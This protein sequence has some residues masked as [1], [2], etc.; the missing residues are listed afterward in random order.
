MNRQ[1]S[2][3]LQARVT[4][5]RGSETAIPVEVWAF[6]EHR[7]GLKPILRKIWA[8]RGCRPIANGHH[9]HQWLDLYRFVRPATGAVVGL[10]GEGVRS[11]L[12]GAAL[13]AFAR[14]GGAGAAK[15]I[16]LVLNEAGGHVS[17]GLEVPEGMERRF[18]P[19]YSPEI[20]AAE[21]LWSL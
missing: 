1:C 20:Q 13:A 14:E 9:R 3:K 5:L 4:E 11:S 17:E 10:I 6:D 8:P 21:R 15:P 2:K 19:A 18:L 16:T 12:L 7:L